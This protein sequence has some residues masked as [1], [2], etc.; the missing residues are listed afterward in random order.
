MLNATGKYHNWGVSRVDEVFRNIAKEV[1]IQVKAWQVA[2]P[3]LC[4]QTQL[5]AP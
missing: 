5:Q 4:L 2:K 3:F 1:T